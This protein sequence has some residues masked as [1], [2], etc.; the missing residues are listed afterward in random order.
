MG[1]PQAGPA[2]RMAASAAPDGRRATEGV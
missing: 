1:R 2:E